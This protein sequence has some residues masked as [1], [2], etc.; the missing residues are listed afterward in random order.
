[1]QTDLVMDTA[2]E[3]GAIL[4]EKQWR[5]ATA[6]SCTGGL[7]AAACTEA[8][9]S[10]DWYAGS[11]VAYSN[12]VKMTL[13][14]VAGDLLTRVGAVSEEVVSIMAPAVLTTIGAH[15]SVA[16]SGIAGPDGG[17]EDKP[18][19]TVWMAWANCMGDLRAEI[20]HFEGDRQS[21]REQAVM[22]ALDGLKGFLR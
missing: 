16:V 4:R 1:M 10:S 13:L 18:V 17:T 15:V 14:G 6:E 20:F 8:P 3:L 9:G 5:L 22:A 21:V 11:V 7:I 2:A 12:N 19:G